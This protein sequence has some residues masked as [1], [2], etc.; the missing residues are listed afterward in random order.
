MK[1]DMYGQ[2]CE[3]LGM[4]HRSQLLRREREEVFKAGTA[5]ERANGARDSLLSACLALTAPICLPSSVNG[6]DLTL[7]SDEHLKDKKD[8]RRGWG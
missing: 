4:W 2:T 8:V 5:S 3:Q 1:Y 7:P 6:A